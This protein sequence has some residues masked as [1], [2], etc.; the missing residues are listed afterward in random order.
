MKHLWCLAILAVTLVSLSAAR[1]DKFFDSEGVRIR[2][3]EQGSGEPLVLIHGYSSDLERAWVN[4]G[5]F[6]NL[7]TDHRVI[8]LDLRGH[9]GS[10]KPRD[11]RAYGEK[12]GQDVV[13]L[14]DHLTL[15]RAHI[16]GYSLGAAIVAKLVTT[17]P[18]RFVTA[19]VGGGSFSRAPWTPQREQATEAAAT[20]LEGPFPFLSRILARLPREQPRP[21]DE[22]LRQL[23]EAEVRRT[24]SDPK[25]L[26][27]FQ[28]SSRALVVTA[29]DMAAIR[30]PMLGVVGSRDGARTR[31]QEL[32]AILPALKLVV[33]DG[34]VH[35]DVVRGADRSPEFVSA[36][37]EFIAAHRIRVTQPP[38][39]VPLVT[40][41]ETRQTIHADAAR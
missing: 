18:E 21:T 7:A 26:A 35:S 6:S 11:P 37:R 19:T 4:G 29:A 14:L 38:T 10:D 5:V 9:G 8:A 27:A 40:G 41:L 3:V 12:M 28:R 34:A 16:V 1:E 39:M 33:I 30:V 36:L 15:T 13:R 20:E 24:Q 32:K 22:A 31:L 25:A 17:N 2:Y 23:S